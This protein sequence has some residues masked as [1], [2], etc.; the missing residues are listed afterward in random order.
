VQIRPTPRPGKNEELFQVGTTVDLYRERMSTAHDRYTNKDRSSQIVMG[1]II[2][3]QTG[4]KKEEEIRVEYN[5]LAPVLAARAKSSPA[6]TMIVRTPHCW[7]QLCTR[8]AAPLPVGPVSN[9]QLLR[10]LLR[11]L[12]LEL[13]LLLLLELRLVVVVVVVVAAMMLLVVRAICSSVNR[14]IKRSVDC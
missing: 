13:L 10:E 2:M 7:A 4:R 8:A 1:V 5:Y 3:K 6:L 9:K 14:F 11:K 12:E